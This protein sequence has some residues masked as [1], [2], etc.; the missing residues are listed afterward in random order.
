ML[1]S[2]AG[3]I[4]GSEILNGQAKTHDGCG[5]VI[6]EHAADSAVL[7]LPPATLATTATLPGLNAET[8]ANV[9]S[10]AGQELNSEGR[11]P[12]S[13]EVGAAIEVA[14]DRCEFLRGVSRTQAA[15]VM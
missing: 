5:F 10:V 14:A 11:S 9:A 12:V 3:P 8:V 2:V 7:A 4:A 6:P 1:A 15:G 13:E